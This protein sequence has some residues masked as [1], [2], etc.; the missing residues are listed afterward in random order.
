MS[1]LDDW[2]DD[3]T[4]DMGEASEYDPPRDGL[5]ALIAR[6]AHVE[7]TLAGI[8]RGWSPLRQ[9]GITV[10]EDG[11]TIDSSLTV[12]GDLMSTGDA[13]FGGTLQ[14]TGDAVFSGDLAVP[15]GSI[16]NEALQNPIE[17]GAIGYS[18]S[19]FAVTTTATAVATRTMN[20]PDGFTK[21]SVMVIV[22]IGAW[23]QSASSGYLLG[24]ATIDGSSGGAV[25]TG[26]GAGGYESVTASAIRTLEDLTP[27]GQ[28]TVQATCWATTNFGAST[29][30]SVNIDAIA[31]F[32]R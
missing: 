2:S 25:Q 4:P 28:I 24:R 3:N 30:N 6:L 10:T 21:A 8:T 29:T 14:V 1:E 7:R 27:G 13:A 15:N 31:I 20:I 17:E 19:N 18:T 16:S 23:N 9:A 11:M 12:D 22:S 5:A 32:R 26:V